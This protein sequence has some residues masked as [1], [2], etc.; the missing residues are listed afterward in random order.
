VRR[1]EGTGDLER[2]LDGFPDRQCP[3]T[4]PLAQRV[5]FKQLEDD[6]RGAVICADVETR[7]DVRRALPARTARGVPDP[8]KRQRQHFNG[9]LTSPPRIACPIHLTHAA[10][11]RCDD[12]A[13][14]LSVNVSCLERPI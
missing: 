14:S 5:A 6:V 10:A 11:E 1:R 4:Q 12:F 2:S 13:R 3:V 8:T 7:E 9:D